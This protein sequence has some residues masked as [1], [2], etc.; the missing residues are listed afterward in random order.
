MPDVF[1]AVQTSI[2]RIVSIFSCFFSKRKKNFNYE[3]ETTFTWNDTQ[4][5]EVN[6]KSICIG[7]LTESPSRGKLIYRS[8]WS[9]VAVIEGAARDLLAP[10]MLPV[11][12]MCRLTINNT[13]E[14]EEE[15]TKVFRRMRKIDK[16]K[17]LFLV[18]RPQTKLIVVFCSETRL[19]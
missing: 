11:H 1:V 4:E 14:G 12:N 9:R 6:L 13:M 17:I 5:H 3:L 18:V 2:K 16:K 7:G 10:G 19:N 15:G 8:W